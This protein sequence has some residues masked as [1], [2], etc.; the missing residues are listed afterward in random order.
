MPKTLKTSRADRP[1]DLI[2]ASG[3]QARREILQ[4]LGLRFRIEAP[5]FDESALAGV[6]AGDLAETLALGKARSVSARFPDILV[7]G[8]DQVLVLD[9]QLLRKPAD[10]TQAEAQLN[11]LNGK[12]HMLITG[13]ALVCERTHALRISNEATRLTMRHLDPSEIKSNVATGEWKGCVGSYR[14]EGQGLKLFERVEGDLTN[15]REATGAASLQRL[16]EPGRRA[17]QIAMKILVLGASQGTG[18]CCVKAALARGH[19][20]TAFSRTP[21]KLDLTHP[22]LTKVAGDFHDAAAVRSAVAGQDAVIICVSPTSL[23]TI[24]E[25]PDYFS[26]G[27]R[28]CID[29]MKEQGV[30]R[31]VVL[32]AHGVGDSYR[33]ASWFQRTFLIGALLKGFFRDHDVQERLTRESGLDFVI[34]RPTRLTNG[35]AKGKYVRTAEVVSVPSTISRADLAD[36]MVE[37]CESPT[38]VGQAVHLGG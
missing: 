6:T 29:A 26:R 3:S 24:K 2:L 5:Q 19:S 20:V 25:K 15:A 10:A 36:F 31:L 7:L 11:A 22:A 1:P 33:V 4:A 18:A 32:T 38:R 13:M 23:G 37:A 12:Q 16:A 35:K 28:Y 14:V 34:A 27:T 30:K 9:G 17:F 8:A 21:A